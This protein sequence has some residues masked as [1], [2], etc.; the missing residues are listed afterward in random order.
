MDISV[1]GTIENSKY[2]LFTGNQ[3]FNALHPTKV[4][5]FHQQ[6]VCWCYGASRSVTEKVERTLPGINFRTES[7]SRRLF[8]SACWVS[9]ISDNR[10]GSSM[11]D[12]ATSLG[13]WQHAKENSLITWDC[14]TTNTG[15]PKYHYEMPEIIQIYTETNTLIIWDIADV[16]EWFDTLHG[17]LDAWIIVPYQ[18]PT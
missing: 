10:Y 1:L 18:F 12:F 6:K 4:F 11:G 3:Y 5:Q 7:N 16:P 14:Q 9:W 15:I 2:N 8:Q 17:D 13:T